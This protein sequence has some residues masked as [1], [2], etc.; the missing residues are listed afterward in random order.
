MNECVSCS[1]VVRLRLKGNLVCI[2]TACWHI[3]LQPAL[4]V[5]HSY[6]IQLWPWKGQVLL[7]FIVLHILFNHISHLCSIWFLYERVYSVYSAVQLP[8]AKV[9]IRFLFAVRVCWISLPTI[10]SSA[11]ICALSGNQL[12]HAQPS[13]PVIQIHYSLDLI[14]TSEIIDYSVL[15]L[16][17]YTLTC[18]VVLSMVGLLS[19][20]LAALII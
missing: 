15:Q 17:L 20:A 5:G 9:F 1:G 16:R 7:F 12:V 2:V 14:S 18:G 19:W 11:G 4:I 6:V 13:W 10:K 8:T 3:T